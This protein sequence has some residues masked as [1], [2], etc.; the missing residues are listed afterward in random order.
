MTQINKEFLAEIKKRKV[1]TIPNN[2]N[3]HWADFLADKVIEQFPDEELYTCAAGI[4]PSGVIHFGNFRDITTNY[5]VVKALESKG[6]KARLLF[7]LDSYDRFRK[8]PAGVPD[9]YKQY[10]GLPVTKVPD[11]WGEYESYARRFEV[12]LE[13][14]L[15]EL[16]M[17]IEFRYQTDLFT[18]GE[19]VNGIRTAFQKRDVIAGILWDFMS[20]RS[21][22]EKSLDEKEYKENYF[23]GSVYSRFTGKD[24]TQ[25][26]DYDGDTKVTYRCLET[27]QEET[28]DFSKDFCV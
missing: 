7:S 1:P 26:L 20:D 25:I 3:R 4:T 2:P 14:A 5:A 15:G 9:D 27:E 28:I 17:D 11:P 24:T 22:K 23:P 8:V 12:E 21:K 16:D 10:L 18:S 13:E 6:K 19:Y